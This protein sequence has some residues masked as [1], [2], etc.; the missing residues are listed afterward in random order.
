MQETAIEGDDV[1]NWRIDG[2]LEAGEEGATP[3]EA[4]A[5]SD[6]QTELRLVDVERQVCLR[7]S[8]VSDK[9]G[10]VYAKPRRAPGAKVAADHWR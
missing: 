5:E 8:F 6:G 9:E 2:T 1:A 3:H 4:F 7:T 10:V